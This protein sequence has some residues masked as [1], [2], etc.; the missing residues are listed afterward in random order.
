MTSPEPDTGRILGQTLGKGCLAGIGVALAF[1]LIG[2]LVYGLLS[3]FGVSENMRLFFAIASG[4]IIGTAILFVVALV[5]NF[6]TRQSGDRQDD[7]S[8]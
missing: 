8:A 6:R 4:P 5:L 2:A 1:F 3:L 7:G